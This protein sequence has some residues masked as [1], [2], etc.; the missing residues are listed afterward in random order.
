MFSVI[1][2]TV[3]NTACQMLLTAILLNTWQ[4]QFSLSKLG[5]QD[6]QIPDV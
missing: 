3:G 4:H 2:F 5:M 6:S 1:V